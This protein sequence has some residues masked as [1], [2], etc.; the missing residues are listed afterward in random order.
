MKEP[1]HNDYFPLSEYED[2]LARLRAEMVREGMDGILLSTEPNVVY[3]TGLLNGYW[4]CTMHDDSQLALISADPDDE[5]ILLLPDNLEQTARTSCVSD[6][7]TWSQFTGGKGKGS[8]ATVADGFADRQLTKARVGLEIGPH[9]RPGMSLPFLKELQDALPGVQ[10]LD[11]TEVMKQ[12]RKVKSPREIDKLRVACEITCQA[13]EV[14]MDA[15][16]EGM[17]EKQLGHI[18]AQQIARLSPDACV[19]HPW[20]IFVHASGR[21]PAAYDGIPSNYRFKKGDSVYLDGGLVYQGYGADMIRCAVIGKPSRDQERYYYASRDAN[22]AAVRHVRPGMKVKELY[23]CWAN[24]V[25]ELGFEDSLRNQQEADWDFLGHGL[26]L[27]IHELPLLNSTGEEVL[28]PGMVMAIEGNVFDKFPFRETT[29]SLKN[30]E[31]VLVTE[32]GYEWL[33]PLPNDLWIVEK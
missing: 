9:D 17:S 22:M 8:I 29:I 3:C 31:D 4:I 12:V 16:K 32:D 25:C 26:G 30:E 19:N 27:T 14:G 1:E 6:I 2:R 7:R 15:I 5:P 28:E 18:I 20:V 24:T 33:T 23:E 13:F 10:W 11:S 21:G